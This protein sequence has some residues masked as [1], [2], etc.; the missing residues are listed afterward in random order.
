MREFDIQLLRLK[1]VLG[2]T[3]DQ[4]VAQFLGMTKHAFSDRKRRGAFPMDKVLALKATRPDLAIDDVY[5][6]TGRDAQA[7]AD[8]IER[9]A[10]IYAGVQRYG[11]QLMEKFNRE[12][13][14]DGGPIPPEE[15][16]LHCYMNATDEGK[17]ML[18]ETARTVRRLANKHKSGKSHE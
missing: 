9:S 1:K 17:E 7:D 15:E 8:D 6:L 14:E 2:V 18:L 12:V 11:E 4:Q 13:R 10:Q 5:I 3:E 16:L